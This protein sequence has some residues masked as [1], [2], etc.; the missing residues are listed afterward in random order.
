MPL[1]WPLKV[2]E[3]SNAKTQRK[4]LKIEHSCLFIHHTIWIYHFSH[5]ILFNSPQKSLLKS[6]IKLPKPNFRTPKNPGIANFKPK[7]ILRSSPSLEI[8]STPP[9]GVGWLNVIDNLIVVVEGDRY[10]WGPLNMISLVKR[11]VCQVELLFTFHLNCN[12]HPWGLINDM[13]MSIYN[14]K[15]WHA[16]S[17]SLH[18]VRHEGRSVTISGTRLT[19]SM[20]A[21]ESDFY[22]PAAEL[23]VIAES[24]NQDGRPMLKYWS[25]HHLV[26]RMTAGPK[27]TLQALRFCV[28]LIVVLYFWVIS[29]IRV[30]AFLVCGLLEVFV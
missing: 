3:R 4:T 27:R 25:T 18:F 10:P 21:D 26:L 22:A 23:V 28:S 20:A 1:L 2:P 8:P 17:H 12:Y 15:H 5:L 16:L 6:Q 19:R 9:G 30:F 24:F 7:K 11:L 14:R 29:L 13:Q